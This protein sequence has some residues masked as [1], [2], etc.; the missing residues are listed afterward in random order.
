MTVDTPNTEKKPKNVTDSSKKGELLAEQALE[1]EVE[2][3][4]SAEPLTLV[5]SEEEVRKMRQH[6]KS[7]R[8]WWFKGGK[9]ATNYELGLAPVNRYSKEELWDLLKFERAAH[10]TTI[11]QLMKARSY[12]SKATIAAVTAVIIGVLILII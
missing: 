7:I 8:D 12:S 9:Y 5:E 4:P 2:D 11:F 6:L 10:K 1:F 3:P